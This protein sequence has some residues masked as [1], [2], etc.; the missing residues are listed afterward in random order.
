MRVASPQ[1]FIT[2][3]DSSDETGKCCVGEKVTQLDPNFSRTSTLAGTGTSKPS[4]AMRVFSFFGLDDLFP[5]PWE[6]DDRYKDVRS[7]RVDDYPIGYGRLAAHMSSD[8]NFCVY[9]RFGTA[10]NRVILRCQTEIAELE[11]A[12]DVIER[13]ESDRAEKTGGRPRKLMTIHDPD[14]SQVMSAL[15]QKLEEYDN[16]L[17]REQKSLSMAKPTGRNYR[18]LLH[19]CWNNKPMVR[20]ESGHLNVRDDF[21]ILVD[22]QNSVIHVFFGWLLRRGPFKRI[23]NI[24]RTKDQQTKASEADNRTVLFS[25]ERFTT[26]FKMLF[27]LL[28]IVMLLVP[29]SILY[30]MELTKMA[31]LFVVISFVLYFPIMVFCFSRRLKS[32]ELLSATAAYTAVLVACLFLT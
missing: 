31:R 14:M 28:V 15:S 22:D 6:W 17:E 5:G 18:T 29:V 7:E 25:Q 2:G 32:Q 12:I 8:N 19:W 30:I 23:A 1:T 11:M 13:E 4:I 10:R 9:R 27:L 24:F 16:L 26:F 21:V 20:S 3:G